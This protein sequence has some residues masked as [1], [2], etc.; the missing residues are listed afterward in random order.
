MA[1]ATTAAAIATA[2]SLVRG[3]TGPVAAVDEALVR[4]C[5]GA[6][7]GAV[8]WAWL[9][10][11]SVVAEAWSGLAGRGRVAA[12]WRRL[13]LLCCGVVLAT[14][15]TAATA[16]E[17]PSP[18]P[19]ISGLPFPDRA[20]GPA[21]PPHPVVHPAAPRTVVVRS[22]DCLWHLAAADLP[23]DASAAR[24]TARWQAIHRLNAEV[25]GPDPDLIHPGQRLVLPPRPATQ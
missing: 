3:V 4:L 21:R 14:P 15:L 19:A 23:A 20:T 24:L 17:R 8:V 16:D 18:R 13:V 11:L 2:Q 10:T 12:P 9:A 5:L 1:V 7:L 22:G 25:I 6:L